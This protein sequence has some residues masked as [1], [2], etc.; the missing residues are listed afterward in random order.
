MQ[1]IDEL[2]VFLLKH[3]ENIVDMLGG[4]I[5]RIELKLKVCNLIIKT[6]ANIWLVRVN[7]I[8]TFSPASYKDKIFI[9]TINITRLCDCAVRCLRLSSIISTTINQSNTLNLIAEKSSR[10]STLWSR[11]SLIK[12]ETQT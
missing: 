6:I 12:L 1:S 5:D 10:N 2:E 3:G 7:K 8:N 4:E 11:G 9:T